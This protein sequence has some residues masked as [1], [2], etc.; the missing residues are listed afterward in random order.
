MWLTWVLT[1]GLLV[2]IG[3]DDAT[4]GPTA[5]WAPPIGA[6]H[7]TLPLPH[8]ARDPSPK[9]SAA[10]LEVTHR[11]HGLPVDAHLEM[12][13]RPAAQAGAVAGPDHL[14]L[15]DLLADRDRDRLLVGIAA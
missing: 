5:P 1:G 8:P 9:P 15:A 10:G 11:V 3:P 12:Q 6:P 14:A 4:A 7:H 13:V 2:V